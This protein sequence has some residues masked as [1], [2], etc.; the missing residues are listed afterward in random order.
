[1]CIIAG[2]FRSRR[3]QT[4]RGLDVR[5]TPD[6]L[7]EALFNVIAP[8]LPGCTFVD[9]YAG[10]GSVGIEALSRGAAS[11]IFLERKRAAT[12][13]IRRNLADLGV[14]SGFEVVCAKAAARLASF[15]ADIVFIHRTFAGQYGNLCK[16]RA[17]GPWH[18]ILHTT[19]AQTLPESGTT[20]RPAP[21]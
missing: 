13:R 5:P 8:R 9:A 4:L 12:N 3:I 10:C 21:A 1:M 6:R 17:A 11:V 14:T 2:Q 7:R 19:V 18:H 16:L 15:P 20:P